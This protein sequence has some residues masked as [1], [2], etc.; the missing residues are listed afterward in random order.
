[1]AGEPA[2]EGV[3]PGYEL[4]SLVEALNGPFATAPPPPAVTLAE[5]E[6]GRKKKTKTRRES[7]DQNSAGKRSGTKGAR[8]AGRAEIQDSAGMVIY[9]P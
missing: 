3:P 4:V 1:M 8:R 6:G 7:R 5:A 9:F 2:A